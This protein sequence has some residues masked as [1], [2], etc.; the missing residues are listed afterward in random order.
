MLIVLA[1]LPAQR[2][3][4]V[5]AGNPLRD[6]ADGIRFVPGHRLF[7][8]VIGLAFVSMFFGSGWIQI[9]PAYVDQFDG[10]SK[11]VGYVFSAAGS[12]AF[13]GILISGRV[14]R[15]KHYGKFVL[16][17]CLLFSS[18]LILVALAP[19]L[20][21]A[22]AAAFVAHLGNGFF[23]IGTASILQVRVP[24]ALRGRVMGIYSVISSLFVL[25]GLFT[26][27][28]AGLFGIRYGLLVGPAIVIS[29]ALLVAAT[30]PMF[31]NVDDVGSR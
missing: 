15:H 10:G 18:S 12:G 28:M 6:L 22:L 9:L 8:A 31:R 1:F 23:T 21:F 11:E 17:A 26:G 24:E 14:N 2:V 3:R 16:G 20:K 19:S 4:Q 5:S 25:G 13:S 7:T 27:S 30:Q 29:A